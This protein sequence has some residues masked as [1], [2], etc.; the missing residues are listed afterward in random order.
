MA[1][2]GQRVT[3]R[4][5]KLEKRTSSVLPA[6]SLAVSNR[7]LS[8]PG[9]T[10][11]PHLGQRSLTPLFVPISRSKWERKPTSR[12]SHQVHRQ[13]ARGEAI[14]PKT[15]RPRKL[16]VAERWPHLE[17]ILSERGRVKDPTRE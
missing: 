16:W 2:S 9:K 3:A 6:H 8:A 7:S 5:K 4:S 15:K 10:H 13:K 11:L 12:A 14:A 1:A 17:T